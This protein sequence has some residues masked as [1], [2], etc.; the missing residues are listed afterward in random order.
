MEIQQK[1]PRIQQKIHIKIH[2]LI[3]NKGESYVH[4]NKWEKID[5]INRL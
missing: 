5:D 1:I 3:S 4:Y 2:C